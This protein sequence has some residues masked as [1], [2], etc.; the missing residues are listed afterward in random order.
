MKEVNDEFTQ[1]DIDVLFNV[2]QFLDEV[3]NEVKT[4]FI[5]LLLFVTGQFIEKVD[6]NETSSGTKQ[7][8]K[9]SIYFLVNF[10]SKMEKIAKN[11]CT[12]TDA[13]LPKTKSK[14][15]KS[16]KS[17]N[18][19]QWHEWRNEC[20]SMLDRFTKIDVTRVWSMGI[21]QDN[22]ANCLWRYAL[23]LLEE[24]P[25]GLSGISMSDN[26]A[27]QLCI[28]ILKYCSNYIESTNHAGASCSGIYMTYITAITDS[29][30]RYEHMGSFICEFTTKHTIGGCITSD[31]F[32]DIGRMNVVNNDKLNTTTI[33]NLCGYLTYLAE[34]YPEIFVMYFPLIL[35]QID[36][37]I[38]LMRYALYLY[39][40]YMS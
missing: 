17:S 25:L 36:A 2:I 11:S 40:S 19:F 16:K 6:E 4:N 12:N 7:S 30:R 9:L 27:R 1:K 39:Y 31:I 24:K 21:M 23:E 18:E 22:F 26:N 5:E 15:T 3:S 8:L 37:D 33:K 20:L 38:Y 34:K 10:C 32:N 28:S 35:N 14:S 13:V 29:L